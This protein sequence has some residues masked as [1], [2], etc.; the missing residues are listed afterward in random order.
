MRLVT[1]LPDQFPVIWRWMN[2][3]T[4]LPWSSDLRCIG[5]MREDGTVAAAVGFNGWTES[6]CW[7]H[8]AFDTPHSLT[9]A[10]LRAAFDYPFNEVGVEA[11]YGLTPKRIEEVNSMNKKLG[12]QRI[13]ETV[14]A[15]IWEMRREDC[16]WIKE[17][18]HG[19]Q[20]ESTTTS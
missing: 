14:D 18:K 12:F 3:Q 17:Q 7:M 13:G 1:D 4:R 5:T 6:S 10:M 19:R 16:R 20:R 15:I 11:V 2:G 8:V 9:R